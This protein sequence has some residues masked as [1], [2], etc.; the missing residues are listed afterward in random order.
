MNDTENRH[1]RVLRVVGAALFSLYKA[2]VYFLSLLG[3]AMVIGH[4]RYLPVP[5]LLAMMLVGV[6][7]AGCVLLLLLVLTKKF[8]IGQIDQTGVVTIDSAAGKRWFSAAM[9]ASVL[10]YSPFRPMIGG[11][12]M[13]MSWY[14]RGMGAKMP[15]S[16]FMGN[17]VL[18]CD[19]WYLELGEN[20]NIGAEALILGHMGHGKEIKLGHVVIGDEVIVGVRVV[21]CPDVKIGNR[22]RIGAN[23]LVLSGTVIPDGETWAGIPARMISTAARAQGA[24]G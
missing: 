16:V 15:D 18:I 23:S 17:G 1:Q 12:S 3:P 6:G 24:T 7:V 2:V 11:L 5:A 19:P 9:V 8:L 14:Y 20:V 13:F 10:Y 4:F 21:I 22:A